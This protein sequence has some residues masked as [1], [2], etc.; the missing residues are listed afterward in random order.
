[1]RSW[2]V[3]YGTLWAWQAGSDLPPPCP[4]RLA[5]T[6]TEATE[7]DL[8]ALSLALNLPSP[9]PLQERR[10][11][12]RRCFI[13]KTEEQIV[14]YGW[15]THGSEHVGELERHFQLRP[16]EVYI[17]DCGTLPAWR[18]QRCYSALLNHLIYH[19]QPE[20]VPHIWIGASRQ[21]R[22]S[23][24]GIANAGFSHVLDLTYRRFYGLTLL[25]FQQAPRVR[26]GLIAAAYRLLLADHEQRFG[27]LAIGY[28]R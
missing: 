3:E 15:V 18:D 14:S 10:H 4:A 19:L 1:M 12:K 27:P 13:L 28:K 16:D 5:V 2:S 23:V 26:P 6:F 7:P 24:Q 20:G 25:W 11:N 22:P 17:W 9:A 21:N 8:A